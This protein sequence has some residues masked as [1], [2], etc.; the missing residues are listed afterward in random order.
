MDWQP[1]AT[2]GL[3]AIGGYLAGGYQRKARKK[4]EGY[5]A[6]LNKGITTAQLASLAAMIKNA[7]LS[8][9]NLSAGT[10]AAK[11]GSNSG[12]V[13]G[14]TQQAVGQGVAGPLADAGFR[15]LFENMANKRTLFN[16]YSNIGSR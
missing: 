3:K 14:K 12:V 4:A 7:S 1:I 11:Y 16:T 8:Q 9:I 10:N 6:E 5:E 2:E 13:L 15:R